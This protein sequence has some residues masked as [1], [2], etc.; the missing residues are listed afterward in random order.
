MFQGVQL[1][2]FSPY[3]FKKTKCIHR[4]FRFLA[5]SG[6]RYKGKE[7]SDQ[8]TGFKEISINN[9]VTPL[10]CTKAYLTSV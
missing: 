3:F 8:V 5:A 2:Q 1:P 4:P 9:A 7:I 10:T 6:T